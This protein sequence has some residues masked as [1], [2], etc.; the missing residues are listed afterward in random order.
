M[1]LPLHIAW[2]YFYS[3]KSINAINWI[4]RISQAGI[5]IGTMALIIVLSVF[6]GFEQVI[7]SLYNSFDPDFKI[8]PLS[9]KY[10]QLDNDD[11]I[12]IRQME[13]IVSL[14]Q[15]IEENALIKYQDNQTIATLKG[16]SEDFLMATGLDSMI[17]A[18]DPFLEDNDNY[19]AV[20]GAGVASKLGM[21]TFSQSS[22]LQIF[23]PNRK[24]PSVFST[25]PGSL[26]KQLNIVP[27]GIFQVQQDF[28]EKYLIVPLAFIR[29]LVRQPEKYTSIELIVSQNTDKKAVEKQLDEL[30]TGKAVVQNR[31]EQHKWLY[32]IM[33]S[34][35]FVVYLILSFILIIAGFNLIGSLIMLSIEKKKD[36][37]ILN[38][39]GLDKKSIYRVFFYEGM[40]L[41][42]FSAVAG[43]LLGTLVCLIQ[44]KFGIIKLAQGT[45]FVIDAY[46]VAL[47]WMDFLWVFITVVFLGFL[48]SYFPA[49]VALKNLS[50]ED[51][52]Q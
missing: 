3:K 50:L 34:E 25:T 21:N 2:R 39:M 37:M 41:S 38:S 26:F 11:I 33:R 52:N 9:G 13:G 5:T 4:S 31:M 1:N 28:D 8:V 6:N 45:T 15:V 19:Y 30:L 20:I 44:M 32:N 7:L 22:Y 46:P 40:F 24:Q 23:F 42:L 36:M 16:M 17:V 48:S 29:E 27:S 18:G 35:K 47:K 14:S 43:L 10:F 51:L 49:K 12:K